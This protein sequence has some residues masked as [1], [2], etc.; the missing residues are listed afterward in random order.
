[1]ANTVIPHYAGTLAVAATRYFTETASALDDSRYGFEHAYAPKDFALER[2]IIT[3][4]RSSRVK[5][6]CENEL[7][8]LVEGVALFRSVITP[9]RKVRIGVR[10]S[11]HQEGEQVTSLKTNIVSSNPDLVHQ[12]TPTNK[13]EQE[14]CPGVKL[15]SEA[16][17]IELHGL[18]VSC[19][20]RA[21]VIEHTRNC[22]VCLYSLEMLV[23]CID[24]GGYS[25]E[26]LLK[27]GGRP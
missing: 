14:E 25:A 22:N 27:M 4:V 19:D 12:V 23:L 24:C 13:V 16:F 3:Y 18:R 9:D 21:A 5:S 15:I 11:F 8:T 20:E 1:M 7:V 2:V 26:E 10:C 17:G 6:T